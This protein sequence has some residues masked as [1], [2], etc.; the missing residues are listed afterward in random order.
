[1]SAP[2]HAV[3]RIVEKTLKSGEVVYKRGHWRVSRAAYMSQQWRLGGGKAGTQAR[4][5][6]V[7]QKERFLR[8]KLGAPPSGHNWMQIAGKYPER[9]LDYTEGFA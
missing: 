5:V 6:E 9:F 7:K 1:M 2:L 3:G 4:R 8:S